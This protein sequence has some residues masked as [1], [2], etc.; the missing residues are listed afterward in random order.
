M[1]RDKIKRICKD[2]NIT[3]QE[4]ERQAGLKPG[5]IKKWVGDASPKLS[6]AAAVAK[7]LGVSVDYLLSEGD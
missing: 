3:I 1:L 4:L 7:V 2:R 6:N 5:C